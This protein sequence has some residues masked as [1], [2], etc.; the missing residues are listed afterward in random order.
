MVSAGRICPLPKGDW[1]AGTTYNFLDFVNFNGTTYIAKKVTVGEEPPTHSESWQLFAGSVS[2]VLHYVGSIPF[3]GLSAAEKTDG[4]IYNITDAFVTTDEFLE[5]TGYGYAPGSNVM[6]IQSA[7]KWDVLNGT[8]DK[9][10]IEVE[11]TAE[12]W[13]GETAPFT[14]TVT[15]AAIHDRTT[16][17]L[18]TLGSDTPEEQYKP[19]RKAFALLLGANIAEGTVTFSASAK[20]ATTFTVNLLQ[21]V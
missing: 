17:V 16:L 6:W 19:Y 5:G 10:A 15:N 9:V 20:P 7:S 2:S 3:S 11:L 13:T 8:R 4:A 18:S 1:D 12:G 14:N 21:G